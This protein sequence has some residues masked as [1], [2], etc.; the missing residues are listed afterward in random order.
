[1]ADAI[2]AR[3]IAPSLAASTRPGC[4]RPAL[5]HRDLRATTGQGADRQKPWRMRS[6]PSAHR[7]ASTGD[8][9]W[10]RKSRL[11][12]HARS[13]G[14]ERRAD[15]CGRP[16]D[17]LGNRRGRNEAPAADDD[18]D[19]LAAPKETVDRA[20]RDATE[21][22]TGFLDGVERAVLHDALAMVKSEP[23]VCYSPIEAVM[24]VDS[25]V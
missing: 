4:R 23:T 12:R 3:M 19:E 24:T 7:P 18:A 15:G 6:I 16:G 13:C 9:W 2:A 14:G 10:Q 21:E 25:V 1:M 17:K 11:G 22:L 5:E 20:P 8:R